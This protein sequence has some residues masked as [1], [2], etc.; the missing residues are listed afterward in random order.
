MSPGLLHPSVTAW[1]RTLWAAVLVAF[2]P[3]SL[4]VISAPFRCSQWGSLSETILFS[5]YVS[6]SQLLARGDLARPGFAAMTTNFKCC[7]A[8]AHCVPDG[9]PSHPP[10]RRLLAC[11]PLSSAPQHLSPR[12][13]DAGLREGNPVPVTPSRCSEPAAGPSLSAGIICHLSKSFPQVSTHALLSHP[14]TKARVLQASVPQPLPHPSAH[15]TKLQSTSPPPCLIIL[16]PGI[17]SV[18]CR[19]TACS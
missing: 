16:A 7:S 13:G 18:C 8:P 10:P 17:S 4:I 12:L 15:C 1:S 2:V 9:P 11:S 6:S 19:H 14:G 5:A 3:R